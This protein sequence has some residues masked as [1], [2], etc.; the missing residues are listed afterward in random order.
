MNKLLVFFVIVSFFTFFVLILFFNLSPSKSQVKKKKSSWSFFGPSKTPVD[1]E[2]SWHYTKRGKELFYRENKVFPLG[3]FPVPYVSNHQL[4]KV[5]VDSFKVLSKSYAK[6]KEAIFYKGI[7]IVSYT[8]NEVIEVLEREYIKV[9]KRTIY[10]GKV[11]SSNENFK[12]LS[13][14]YTL[15]NEKVF[16]ENIVISELKAE[17]DFKVLSYLLVYSSGKYYYIGNDPDG[18][19]GTL[20]A[21]KFPSESKIQNLYTKDKAIT[22][23]FKNSENVFYKN[24]NLEVNSEKILAVNEKSFFNSDFFYILLR[25]KKDA[26][27][28]NND[29]KLKKLIEEK[30]KEEIYL[31]ESEL[32]GD[33]TDVTPLDHI[34]LFKELYLIFSKKGLYFANT[35]PYIEN[36]PLLQKISSNGH[37]KE[38]DTST[39]IITLTDGVYY[40]D[41]RIGQIVEFSG[42]V[43]E[44]EEY[45]FD[46]KFVYSTNQQIKKLELLDVE[47]TVVHKKWATDGEYLFSFG[48]YISDVY[49]KDKEKFLSNPENLEELDNDK[50][51]EKKSNSNSS[52]E[53]GIEYLII[54]KEA[55]LDLSK[56]EAKVGELRL[57]NFSSSAKILRK[58]F[59]ES[60]KV[61]AGYDLKGTFN[62]K[63]LKDNYTVEPD[64]SVAFEIVDDLSYLK[65]REVVNLTIRVSGFTPKEK[66]KKVKLN[67]RSIYSGAFKI[68]NKK[69]D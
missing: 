35:N 10:D 12:V 55:H 51:K 62:L 52:L 48:H 37:Y 6:D 36:G 67:H 3:I 16:R 49:P 11:V 57:T 32:I 50:D 1:K 38:I 47:K 64:E 23:F 29:F 25:Q 18:D 4:E 53:A 8:E 26:E 42:K 2:K 39:K 28:K 65:D 5:D 45:L 69:I 56:N 34:H 17:K 14:K 19:R 60:I 59:L 24:I 61:S 40:Y 46:D 54:A 13:D 27:K 30:Y 31:S 41:E 44:K 43:R 22:H 66:L 20:K 15:E 21:F 9:G 7:S 68:I 63:L 33:I 58:D